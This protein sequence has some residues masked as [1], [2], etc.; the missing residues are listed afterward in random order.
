MTSKPACMQDFTDLTCTSLMIKLKLQ[1]KKIPDGEPFSCIVR[2]DQRET[3]ETPFSR[4]GYEVTV[5]PEGTNRYIITL[6]KKQKHG[7][8]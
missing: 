6:R 7:N 2:R 4:C 1:L 8:D 5:S 3:I